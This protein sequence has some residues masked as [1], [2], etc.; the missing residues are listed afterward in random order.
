MLYMF[1]TIDSIIQGLLNTKVYEMSYWWYPEYLSNKSF[2]NLMSVYAAPP[3]AVDDTISPQH[4]KESYS[5]FTASNYTPDN[6]D[7]NRHPVH[8]G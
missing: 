1:Y 7:I 4:A 8:V 6:I 3:T 5:Q 2:I